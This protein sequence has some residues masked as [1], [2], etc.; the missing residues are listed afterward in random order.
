MHRGFCVVS[1]ISILK[2][3]H[4]SLPNCL[5]QKIN[6]NCHFL[7]P[8][9]PSCLV[10]HGTCH[11]RF[12]SFFRLLGEIWVSSLQRLTAR[13]VGWCLVYFPW[14]LNQKL[15]LSIYR[16]IQYIVVQSKGP[17]LWFE[18]FVIYH[19]YSPTDWKT[20]HLQVALLGMTTLGPQPKRWADVTI[21]NG[22]E[23]IHEANNLT[24]KYR[25]NLQAFCIYEECK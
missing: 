23:M 14:N 20:L 9:Q 13:S 5:I 16:Y 8:F 24:K 10:F 1:A 6:E 11:C 25:E 21:K 3:S 22:Q 4:K 7:H 17:T 12:E 2:G 15:N 18:Q 19:A